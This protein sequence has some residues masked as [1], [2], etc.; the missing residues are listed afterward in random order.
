MCHGCLCL[1]RDFSLTCLLSF[2]QCLPHTFLSCSRSTAFRVHFPC[3][4]LA[5]SLVRLS[6]FPC[7]LL[8]PSAL[9]PLPVFPRPLL[10]PFPLYLCFSSPSCFPLSRHE[11]PFPR[12]PPPSSVCC[13]VINKAEVSNAFDLSL[14]FL[15][16]LF[17]WAESYKLE[18]LSQRP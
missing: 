12:L 13:R 1:G 11:P 3:S 5:A 2:C 14:C 17:C 7:G 6:V 9:P 4:F 10:L 16:Y 15:V 8:A 18:L